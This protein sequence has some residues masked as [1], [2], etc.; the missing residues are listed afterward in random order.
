MSRTRENISDFDGLSLEQR[1]DIL[2]RTVDVIKTYHG[3]VNR[4]LPEGSKIGLDALLEITLRVAFVKNGPPSPDIYSLYKSVCDAIGATAQSY[5]DISALGNASASDEEANEQFE[6]IYNFNNQ[7]WGFIDKLDDP[8]NT[9][10]TVMELVGK[11]L[12]YVMGCDD[13]LGHLTENFIERFFN[14]GEGIDASASSIGGNASSSGISSSSA[15]PVSIVKKGFS[16]SKDDYNTYLSVGAEIKNPNVDKCASDVTIRVIVKD[17]SGRILDSREDTIQY[18]DSNSVFYYGAELRFSSGTPD[19]YQITVNCDE[20]VPS[21]ANSTIARGISCS[22][23][24]LEKARWGNSTTFT[25]N[26]SNNYNKRLFTDLYFVFYNGAGEIV[27]GA[28]TSESL[29]GQSEDTFS[30]Y[31]NTTAD[32]KTVRFSP[33]FDFMSLS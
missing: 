20:Y 28:R 4:M 12:V 27:G 30:I 23:Y 26:V 3:I 1:E 10:E 7:F 14:N 17:K 31:L 16:L 19:S 29:F 8:E 15:Q 5:E 25:G 21:P 32:R 13:N 9:K 11:T 2:L 33:S 22:H 6:S 18:I 24:N